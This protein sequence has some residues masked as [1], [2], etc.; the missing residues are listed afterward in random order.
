LGTDEYSEYKLL[1]ERYDNLWLDTT[2]VLADYFPG[3]RPPPLKEFRP[4]RIMYGT[5]FPNIPF[6]WD[7]ELKRLAKSGLPEKTMGL[8]L[9]KNAVDFFS[10]GFFQEGSNDQ[11]DSRTPKGPKL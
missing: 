11:S 9:G 10:I 8:I 7:R 5:D 1:I 6:A 4:D 3:H 2:M